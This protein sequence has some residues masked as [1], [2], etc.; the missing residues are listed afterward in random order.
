MNDVSNGLPV[1]PVYPDL[2]VQ[3]VE[4]Y[5]ALTF[6]GQICTSAKKNIAVV[7]AD[8]RGEGGGDMKTKTAY[9]FG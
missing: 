2:K 3:I 7:G 6:P 4:L 8:E 1:S 9:L 5:V